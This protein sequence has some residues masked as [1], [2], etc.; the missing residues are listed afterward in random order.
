MGVTP[1]PSC[2]TLQ[3]CSGEPSS[4][5]P[6]VAPIEFGEPWTPEPVRGDGARVGVRTDVGRR[7]IPILPRQGEVAPQVTEGEDTQRR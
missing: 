4:T 1:S 2:R 7:A 3:P 6:H 5:V